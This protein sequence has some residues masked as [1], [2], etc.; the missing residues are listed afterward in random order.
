MN[1]T[2]VTSDLSNLFSNDSILNKGLDYLSVIGEKGSNFVSS[3]VP[4]SWMSKVIMLLIGLILIYFG[5]KLT[6][7]LAKFGIYILGLILIIG[8]LVSIFT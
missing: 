7:K 3:N 4:S 5:S 8:T 1:L 6:Q 2:D